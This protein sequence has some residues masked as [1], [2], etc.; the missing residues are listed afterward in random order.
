V[1]AVPDGDIAAAEAAIRKTDVEW[2]AAAGTGSVDAWMSFYAADPIVMAPNVQIARDRERVRQTVKSLLTLPHL[3]ISWHPIKVEVAA[4]GDLGYLIGAYEL[5][6]DEAAVRVADQ[7]KLLEI[8]RKQSDGS[9]KCIV[10]TWNSDGPAA[11]VHAAPPASTV[12]RTPSSAQAPSAEYGAM[13]MEYEEAVR[14]YFQKYLK[15]PNSV[16]YREITKPEKGYAASVTGA[17]LTRTTRLAGWTV[18][19]T[20]DAKNSRG[21]YVGFKT[22]TFL[23]RGEKIVHTA[24]PLPEDEM[25]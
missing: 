23:F 7:G 5:S 19:A 16:R 15:D 21:V 11:T 10:D 18:N 22:Y 13:P 25:K 8:W 20:I 2:A 6:Y 24:S 17:L 12:E 3:A 9:W 4:S 14:Q 1:A